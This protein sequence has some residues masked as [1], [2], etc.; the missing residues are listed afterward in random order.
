MIINNTVDKTKSTPFTKSVLSS[1]QD[2]S[3]NYSKNTK[4]VVWGMPPTNN[5]FPINLPGTSKTS[6][7]PMTGTPGVFSAMPTTTPQ[8][9]TTGTATGGG[10]GLVGTTPTRDQQ[11]ESI[12]QQALQIQSQIPTATQGGKGGAATLQT[13][14]TNIGQNAAG[15]STAQQTNDYNALIAS[16]RNAS[17]PN[18]TQ[19][20]LIDILSKTAAGNAPIGE[21][22]R[23]ISDKYA[24]ELNRVG[25]LG[26]GAVAG[27]LSTGSN[28]VGSGN[29]NLAAQSVSARMNAL[30]QA[31]NAELAGVQQQ[32]TAQGQAAG[33]YGTA[34]GG[35]NTQQGQQITGLGSAAGFAQP[36]QV[37][38]GSTLLSPTSGQTVAGGLGGYVN[39]NTAEQVMGLIS[40]YPDAGYQYNPALT[41]QQNLTAA[42][43]AIQASPTY[44]K[45][46]YGVPGQGSVLGATTIQ[47]AQS[48]Y[49][50][51]AQQYN[52][53]YATFTNADAL[54]ENVL[55]ILS[56]GGINPTDVKYA[57]QT[58]KQI[59]RQ[60]SSEQQTRFD[61]ALQE[62]RNAFGGIVASYGGQTPTDI[63][64]AYNTLLN[65]DSSMG[66][67]GAAIEQLKLAGR[68]RLNAEY[69]KVQNY[70]GQ[71]QGASGG[72]GAAGGSDFDW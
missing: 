14:S 42:Q 52:D 60:F 62:A 22:A 19:K 25:Q 40:Q 48:G 65:P 63:G 20:G 28:V 15:G 23:A 57:N 27:N 13:G 58:I 10:T 51:S 47:A 6:T 69:Q 17:D 18:K 11:L 49:Q 33:A 56:Q 66:A 41:P 16:I 53:L 29:A 9:K 1:Q 26:A 35:A 31:Q 38:P 72:G 45:G 8:I 43:Q 36:V 68:T 55:G 54:A 3:K 7:A 50:Q 5:S 61:V 21:S 39:Y 37:A 30:T 46:T 34:L 70:Y 4:P 71:L 44:Q 24:A 2:L 59:K 67:I 12:R 32:L 64:E